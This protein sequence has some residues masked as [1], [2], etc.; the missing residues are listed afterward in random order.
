V[1]IIRLDS[2]PGW[3]PEVENEH[4]MSTVWDDLF[5]SDDFAHAACHQTVDQKGI[6]AFNQAIVIPFKR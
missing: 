2:E 4:G 6:R 1:N 3:S 5:A